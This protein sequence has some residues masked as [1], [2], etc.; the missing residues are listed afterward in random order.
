MIGERIL[1]TGASGY[2]ALNLVNSLSKKFYVRFGSRTEPNIDLPINDYAVIDW[3]SKESLDKACENID[4]IIHSLSLKQNECRNNPTSALKVNTLATS[5]LLDA[6]I[7]N[8]VKSFIYLSTSHVYGR[9]L[10]GDIQESFSANLN[11]PYSICHK[12]SESIIHFHHLNQSINAKV[13]RLSN[14]FGSPVNKDSS[15]WDLLVP[16]LCRQGLFSDRL[17]LRSSGNQSI[18]ILTMSD[19]I[20]F[21]LWF[22]YSD[23]LHSNDLYFNLSGQEHKV[24]DIAQYIKERFKVTKNKDLVINTNNKES[25]DYFNFKINNSKLKGIGFLPKNNIKEEI[26]NLISFCYENL[27]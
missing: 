8:K 5:M 1:I 4:L 12:A 6:A 15:C 19:F 16:D 24:I 23:H 7:K 25:S 26:D 18:N 11:D 9:P 2:L 3:S 27:R 10:Q 14:V 20:E 13:F 17:V 22:L 21:F